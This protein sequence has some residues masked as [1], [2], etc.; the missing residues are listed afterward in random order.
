MLN[1]PSRLVNDKRVDESFLRDSL[2]VQILPGESARWDILGVYPLVNEHSN[3]KPPFLIGETSS[4]GGFPI[5]M[6]VYQGY[7]LGFMY[8][9]RYPPFATCAIFIFHGRHYV[10]L[11]SGE[12]LDVTRSQRGP[13]MENLLGIYG[14]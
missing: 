9:F 3:G 7:M 4:T 1:N 14:L 8:P 13:P 6:L 11:L 10:G 5:A 12:R 2:S